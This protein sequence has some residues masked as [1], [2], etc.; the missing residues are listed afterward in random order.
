[1]SAEGGCTSSDPSVEAPSNV[2]DADTRDTN[3]STPRGR[4]PSHPSERA[5]AIP[6]HNFDATSSDPRDLS[7][8]HAYTRKVLQAVFTYTFDVV[9]SALQLFK[10]PLAVSLY[11]ALMAYAIYAGL[12]AFREPACKMLCAIPGTQVL[13]IC[14]SYSPPVA[15]EF[16]YAMRAD[17]PDLMSLQNDALDKL[18]MQSSTG[19]YLALD[20]KRAELLVRGLV[21]YVTH[22]EL[23]NKSLLAGLLKQFSFD[24]KVTGR[25]LQRLSSKLY[26]AADRY[27]FRSHTRKF[28]SLT[29]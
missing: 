20:V 2:H 6:S 24:A 5:D 29:R 11:I 27:E 3:P 7:S 9:A 28:L 4:S 8:V 23:E 17:Y 19:A 26:N 22:S 13:S 18:L 16:K 21:S 15:S 12:Y 25:D 10:A 1:M 14:H